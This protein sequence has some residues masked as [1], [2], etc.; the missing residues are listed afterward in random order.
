L[1]FVF[2]GNGRQSVAAHAILH[3]QSKESETDGQM[4]CRTATPSK[5]GL[6]CTA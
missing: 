3:L 1:V 5:E 4:S 2:D 6:I